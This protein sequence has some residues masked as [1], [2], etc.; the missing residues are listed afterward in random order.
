[1][2]MLVIKPPLRVR[3]HKK[4]DVKVTLATWIGLP[5]KSFTPCSGSITWV[6]AAE[7]DVP[8]A[9]FSTPVIFS[10]LLIGLGGLSAN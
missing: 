10:I 4:P 2:T 9:D 7:A 6:A 1:M 8:S 3:Y 5:S